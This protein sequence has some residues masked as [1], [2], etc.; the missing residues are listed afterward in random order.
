[1]SCKAPKAIMI[2]L[3]GKQAPTT[4]RNRII[5]TTERRG[6][7]PN[8][9]LTIFGIRKGQVSARMPHDRRNI[10]S[11]TTEIFDFPGADI[12]VAPNLDTSVIRTRNDKRLSGMELD[13]I[14]T[15]IMPFHDKFHRSF[16][17]RPREKVN[18]R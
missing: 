11:V 14:D 2:T 8:S 10:T 9:K 13:P 18:L 16:Q 17:A 4:P 12:I 5:I 6:A 1:M 15:P 3:D 7:I